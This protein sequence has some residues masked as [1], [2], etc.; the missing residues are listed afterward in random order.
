MLRRRL[1]EMPRQA[2]RALQ[3]IADILLIWAALWLAFV[4]RLGSKGMINPFG[5]YLWLFIAAP[6][7]AIPLFVRFGL[8]RAVLR[9]FGGNALLT[10]FN[11]IS[12]SALLLALVIYLLQPE[13]LVP[14]SLTFIYWALS[15]LLIGGLRLV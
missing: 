5:E 1:L 7:T 15:L 14:R 2:K 6:A 4:V 12:L 9:Y 13:Q 11:A 8:Y 3:V 10:M